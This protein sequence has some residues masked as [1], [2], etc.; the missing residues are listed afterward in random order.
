MRRFDGD[1]DG[2]A[3]PPPATPPRRRWRAHGVGTSPA[4]FGTSHPAGRATARSGRARGRVGSRRG[5]RSSGGRLRKTAAWC[6]S[7]SL[8][9]RRGVLVARPAPRSCPAG[10]RWNTRRPWWSTRRLSRARGV[11]CDG[12]GRGT[13]KRA[14][15]K[16]SG[17]R[18]VSGSEENLA[19][20]KPKGRADRMSVQLGFA[21]DIG[22]TMQ[23]SNQ[24]NRKSTSQR[25]LPIT[26][27]GRN[28]RSPPSRFLSSF[29]R[30]VLAFW[31][32]SSPSGIEHR[33]P[34][35][36]RWSRRTASRVTS[37][38]ALSIKLTRTT[39]RC[40]RAATAANPRGRRRE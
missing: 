18:S 29:P 28:R 36:A 16:K 22:V 5:G 37:A 13:P 30:W 8:R 33:A 23:S 3:L 24:P 2:R 6:G 38:S 31:S 21:D 1:G 39:R 32:F 40:R 9:R 14:R 35:R 17:R 34:P 27:F 4:A 25:T 7:R 12:A 10:L 20:G 15:G 19:T 26:E 11:V